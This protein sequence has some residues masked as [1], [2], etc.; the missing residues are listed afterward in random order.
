MLYNLMYEGEQIGYRAINFNYVYDIYNSAV[1][2]YDIVANEDMTKSTDD[3]IK[4]ISNNKNLLNTILKIEGI[5]DIGLDIH[6]GNN[7]TYF[8]TYLSNNERSFV[9]KDLVNF[10]NN[11]KN[12]LAILYGIRRTGKTY[13]ILQS[14]RDL[15]NNGTD[16]SKIIY[17]AVRQNNSIFDIDL[18]SFVRKLIMC[19]NVKYIFI[20]EVTYTDGD[21][22]CFNG[23]VSL[24]KDY[25]IVMSGTCSYVFSLSLGQT[26]YD[27]VDL[28]DVSYISFEDFKK[29]FPH[30]TIDNYIHSGG[31]LWGTEENFNSNKKLIHSNKYSENS[32]IQNLLAGFS[33]F[34]SLSYPNLYKL[35][36]DEQEDVIVSIIKRWLLRKICI[37]SKKEIFSVLTRLKESDK[38]R[39]YY[40]E[41]E[42]YEDYLQDIFN[43][44]INNL[45]KESKIDLTGFELDGKKDRK[46]FLQDLSDELREYLTSIGCLFSIGDN[47]YLLPILYYTC[48]SNELYDYVVSNVGDNFDK[49]I[50]NLIY[51]TLKEF[52]YEE[53]VRIELE[54]RGIKTLKVR[55]RETKEVDIVTSS[56]LIEVKS[57]SIFRKEYHKWLVDEE[58]QEKYKNRKS[59]VL[60]N[61]KERVVIDDDTGITIYYYNITDFLSNIDKYI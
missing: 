5:I 32:I 19:F 23:L 53:I 36:Q 60:Y 11:S 40:R 45:N 7:L 57:S 15:I 37:F 59:I 8:N 30:S 4:N 29:V 26:I 27:R 31:I 50:L 48:M 25:K 54:K 47:D 28:I 61:G 38:I 20:D 46:K 3:G 14:I 24:A 51:S 43:N 13:G 55:I 1:S 10:F 44:F 17:I 21:L 22:C 33:R 49:N 58:I 35:Y 9:N 16:V 6:A 18:M 56:C 12:K 34:R 52:L 2:D 42:I 41:S 39:S